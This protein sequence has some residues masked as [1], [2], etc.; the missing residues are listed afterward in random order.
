[1]TCAAVILTLTD[2]GA[3]QPAL[4]FGMGYGEHAD[5]RIERGMGLLSGYQEDITLGLM[6][7]PEVVDPTM[8]SELESLVRVGR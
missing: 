1:M 5:G 4:A 3:A 8:F 7:H 6:M 2:G